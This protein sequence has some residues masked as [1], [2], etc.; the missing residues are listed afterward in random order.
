V[1]RAPRRA[2]D[3][4]GLCRRVLVLNKITGSLPSSLSALMLLTHLC[5]YEHLCAVCI[6]GPRMGWGCAAGT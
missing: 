6:G 3:G 2:A 5:A 4:L 1:C